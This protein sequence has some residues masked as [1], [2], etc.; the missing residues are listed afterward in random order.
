MPRSIQ[1]PV[2]AF[3]DSHR[4][5]SLRSFIRGN[6]IGH[7]WNHPRV[8][9]TRKPVDMQRNHGMMEAVCYPELIYVVPIARKMAGARPWIFLR[10]IV[11]QWPLVVEQH[12]VL[13]ASIWIHRDRDTSRKF[14]TILAIVE[15]WGGDPSD[16]KS[17]PEEGRRSQQYS[18]D[19]SR[20]CLLTSCEI[21]IRIDRKFTKKKPD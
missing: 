6:N 16:R 8:D 17:E 9:L 3:L 21:D 1:G 18:L 5:F 20:M 15:K 19:D 4:Q 7:W 2:F 12:R 13:L 11:A 10:V 14:S